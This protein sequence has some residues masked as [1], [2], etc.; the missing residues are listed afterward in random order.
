MV[1]ELTAIGKQ[2]P[3]VMW[4]FTLVSVA[5]VGIPPTSAS[6]SKEFLHRAPWKVDLVLCLISI[7]WYF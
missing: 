1:S 6:V 3:V 4:C 7:L 5:L 2:M